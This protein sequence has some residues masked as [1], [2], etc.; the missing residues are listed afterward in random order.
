MRAK[1]ALSA[2]PRCSA[3]AVV[4]PSANSPGQ[5]AANV[6]AGLLPALPAELHE[7]LARIHREQVREN[8]RGPY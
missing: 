6:A 5:V 2:C 7:A 3:V 1:P 4:I 8:V